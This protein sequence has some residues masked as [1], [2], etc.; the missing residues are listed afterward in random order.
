MPL[1]FTHDERNE[2]IPIAIVGFDMHI[3]A[4]FAS[5]KIQD[6][7]QRKKPFSPKRFSHPASG[8]EPLDLS[9]R[10][11]C[12]PSGAFRRAVHSAVVDDD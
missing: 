2:M 9:Q 6:L 7:T 11:I 12:D 4:D 10:Q 1:Q 5:D 3:Q 8:I